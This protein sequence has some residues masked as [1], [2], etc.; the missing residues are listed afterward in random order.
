[1]ATTATLGASRVLP[2]PDGRR[3]RHRVAGPADA[4]VTVVLDAGLGMSSATWGCVVPLLR[5]RVR[6][7]AYDRAGLGGSDP[8]PRP[9]T[10]DRLAGDLLAL[11]DALGEGPFV[12]VG[13]SWAGPIVRT[14]A[15]RADRERLRGLLLLDPTDERCDLFLSEKMAKRSIVTARWLPRLA[16]TGLLRL[17][18]RFGPGRALPADARADHR[19]DDFSPAAA[20]AL[21]AEL[22]GFVTEIHRLRA[23][24]PAIGDLPLTIVSGQ[25]PGR[26]EG[27]DRP[28]VVA[29]HRA[30]A[31]AAPRGRFVPAERS[32]H[33]ALLDDPQ[34]VADEILRLALPA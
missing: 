3:L 17:A 13:H 34:L 8:D 28:G 4:P 14:A 22:E 9:R 25:V 29:A 5:D 1:M 18:G 32:S 15:A 10:L 33:H 30:S 16:R 6:T 21:A 20:R 31:A 2:L 7:V 26:G 23:D 11:L 24:P 19:R 12:L 27:R